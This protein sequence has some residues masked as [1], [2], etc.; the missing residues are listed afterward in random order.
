MVSTPVKNETTNGTQVTTVLTVAKFAS[1]RTQPGATNWQKGDDFIFVDL[2]TSAAGFAQTPIYITSIAGSNDH[3]GTTGASSVYR[4]TAT[5]FR[6]YIRWEK[7][8][9]TEVLTPELANSKQWHINW[10]GFE[11]SS[12]QGSANATQ[13]LPD[14]TKYYYLV[15]KKSGKAIDVAGNSMDNG[16]KVIQYSK[17]NTSHQQWQFQDAGNGYYYIVAKHSGKL[18]SIAGEGTQDGNNIHQWEKVPNDFQRWRLEDAGDGYFYIVSKLNNKVVDVT[19]G[20]IDNSANIQ[21]YSKNQTDAQKWKFE[22]V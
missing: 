13:P 9:K 3:Y 1:G 19:N 4:A 7:D 14:P 21:Q 11:P 5:G 8:Y 22:A 16:G 20:S 6:V 10:I 18:L 17:N 15:N 2:D 12:G